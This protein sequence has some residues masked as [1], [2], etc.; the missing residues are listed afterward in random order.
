MISDKLEEWL[1]E[2]GPNSDDVQR[3]LVLD[4]AP[5][6][7]MQATKDALEQHDTVVYVP[8]G[9]TSLLQPADVFWNRPF[10][11]NLLQLCKGLQTECL[12]LVFGSDSE[13]SFGGFE[14]D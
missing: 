3:L 11:A 10:K 8:A 14:S 5:I 12:G 4:Q 2:W 6:H 9:C 13:D 7:K 1:Q